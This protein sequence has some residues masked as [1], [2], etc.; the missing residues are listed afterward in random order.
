[1]ERR[2]AFG[3][4]RAIGGSRA[5][6]RGAVLGEAFLAGLVAT[7]AALL[8]GAA[9]AALLLGVI[10]PQSFGWTVVPSVPAGRLAAAAAIVLAASLVAGV[11]PGRIAAS[12]DPASALAEE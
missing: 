11:V 4:L 1:V 10:N 12:S 9:F 6:I 3:L 7:F 8:A 5:Q 2:R